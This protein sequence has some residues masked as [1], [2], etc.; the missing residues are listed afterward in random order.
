MQLQGQVQALKV[1]LAS[2][3]DLPSVPSASQEEADLREKV[4]NF[5]PGTVN[6]NRGTAVY[7]L[8]DQPFQ[9]QKHIPFG[10]RSNWPDLESDVAGSGVPPTTQLPPYSSTLFCMDLVRCR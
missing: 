4:F 3:K 7:S 6:T 9:F 1:T 8:P 5:V 2:Q 10:D